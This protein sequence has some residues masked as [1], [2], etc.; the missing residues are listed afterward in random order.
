MYEPRCDVFKKGGMK[1]DEQSCL[2]YSRQTQI[3]PAFDLCIPAGADLLF[4]LVTFLLT[5]YL[6]RPSTMTGI[7]TTILA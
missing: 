3:H 2:R 6:I 4:L 1:N 7:T 5:E